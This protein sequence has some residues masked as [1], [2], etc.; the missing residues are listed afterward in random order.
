MFPKRFQDPKTGFKMLSSMHAKKY[1]KKI[2]FE[3]EDYFFWKQVGK[4]L[5]CTYTIMGGFW[6]YNGGAS[7]L[8][9]QLKVDQERADNQQRPEEEQELDHKQHQQFP[10]ASNLEE[11]KEFV[12][13]IGTKIG[14][15]G[16]VENDKELDGKKFEQEAQKLWMKMRNEV[17]SELQEKGI[18]VE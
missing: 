1:L 9:P 10:L 8:K 7:K 2:G 6:L 16:M 12:S 13:D 18:D 15:K 14:L 4:A 3:S 5:L 17:V 11:M